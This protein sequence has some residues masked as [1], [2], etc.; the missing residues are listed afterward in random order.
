MKLFLMLNQTCLF[1][2]GIFIRG[3][4]MPAALAITG[5]ERHP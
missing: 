3:I 1:P 2:Q 4:S 5:A